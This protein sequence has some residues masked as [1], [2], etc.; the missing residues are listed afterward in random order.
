MRTAQI[1]GVGK[2]ELRELELPPAGPGQVVLDVS[3]CGVCG[4]NLH[5]WHRPTGPSIVGAFGHEVTAK[6]SAVGS[7]VTGFVVDQPVTVDPS[8]IGGCQVCGACRDGA[9]W[10]CSNKQPVATYG[11]ADQMLVPA[12][13]LYALPGSVD[14]NVAV[15][16]EP[17]ACGVHAIRHCWTA[18]DDGRIDGVKVTV[19]GAGMLGLG[20]IMAARWLGAESVTAVARYP[21]QSAA[22]AMCGA[23]EVLQSDEPDLQRVLRSRRPDIVVEA[24]GGDAPTM[25]LVTDVAAWRGEVV[26]LGSFTHP[27]EVD[28]G[29]LGR[30]EVRL[31]IPVAYS[32]RDGLSDFDVALQLLEGKG[33]LLADLVTHRFALDEIDEAF[34]TASDK[35]SRA[36]RVVVGGSE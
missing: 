23:D 22:A 19:V 12:H 5:D 1:T 2:L 34:A 13:A 16:T 15:L 18:R 9:P 8:A 36:I 29:R 26:V 25:D 35:S 11:F 33:A 14:P 17:V 7:D 6:V 24:V 21:H 4:S 32:S 30:R 27:K 3:G 10:F 31:F 28:L 20:A